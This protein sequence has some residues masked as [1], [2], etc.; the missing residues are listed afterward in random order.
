MKKQTFFTFLILLGIIFPNNTKADIVPE[1]YSGVMLQG[2]YWDS[3]SLTSWSQLNAMAAEIG[4]NFDLIW[5]PP[6]GQGAYF[7]GVGNTMDMGYH[8]RYWSNQNSAWGDA[9]G[10]KTLISSL[11][12]NGC[13]AI[14]D[15]VVNHRYGMGNDTGNPQTTNFCTFAQDNFGAYGTFQLTPAHFCTD[16]DL[17]SNSSCPATGNTDTGLRWDLCPDLDHTNLY[18]QQDICAYLKWLKDEYGYAGWR[19]DFAMGFGGQYLGGYNTASNPEFSVGEYWTEQDNDAEAWLNAT[20][21]RSS[22]FDFPGKLNVLNR[23]L[24]EKHYNQMAFDDGQYK[25]PTEL[26][27][28]GY[29]RYL[30]SFVDN[31]DTYRESTKFTGDVP[32]AYA[33]ILSAPGVPCVFWTHWRENKNVINEMIAARKSMGIHSE[34]ET[35]VTHAEDLKYYE[36]ITTGANGS[37]ICRIGTWTAAAP[38]G[39]ETACSGN[40]WAF[41]TKAGTTTSISNSP[42]SKEVKSVD[43]FTVSG[44]KASKDFKGL[45]IKKTTCIDGEVK[46]EK[47]LQ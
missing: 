20:T 36:C 8:P 27:K 39:Y 16:N 21:L 6:S 18:V 7:N 4:Q 29:S 46:A 19:Y 34:S 43:Y 45:V 23:S 14:A 13:K 15:I 30:V 25:R 41:Y 3:F 10:L 44:Q 35:R 1:K 22:V 32:Q 47:V 12:G 40:G 17:Y 24:A 38:A 37:L 2:F 11:K 33:F 5:L 42:A 28:R 31:H 26:M 9:A